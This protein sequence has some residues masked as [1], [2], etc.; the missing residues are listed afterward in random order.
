MALDVPGYALA[1]FIMY[2][3]TGFRREDDGSITVTTR[4]CF[5]GWMYKFKPEIAYPQLHMYGNMQRNLRGIETERLALRTLH[6]I[7]TFF[8]LGGEYQRIT[9]VVIEQP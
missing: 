6:I 5:A 4:E 1:W 7:G 2:I 3:L 9:R 8:S